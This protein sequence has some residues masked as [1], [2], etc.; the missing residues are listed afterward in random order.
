MTA[1]NA[2]LLLWLLVGVGAAAAV[3]WQLAHPP[4]P[5]AT[6]AASRP[7]ELP[8]VEPMRLFQ[9]PPL[10]QYGEIV[11]HPLFIAAR[12]P[13]PPP[14]DEASPEEPSASPGLEQKLTLL[15]VMI[16]SNTRK[17]L[18]RS[19]EP[20]AKT[21]RM[22]PGETIGEWRLEAVFSDRVVLRKGQS[23]QALPL[24]RPQ[25]PKSPHARQSGAR[26][27]RNAQ[28]VGRPAMAPKPGVPPPPV[29]SSP[30]QNNG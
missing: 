14:P 8:S 27:G 20:N 21:A 15:G 5:P 26:R 2:G 7:P 9:L 6:S 17:A 16:T 29:V 1:R 19:E 30:Q 24:I 25:K 28:P 4:R 22:S 13:E 23:T 11:L 12:E 10:N 18:L 3:Y